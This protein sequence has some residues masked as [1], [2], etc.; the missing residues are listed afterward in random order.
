MKPLVAALFAV[1]LAFGGSAA[2]LEPPVGSFPRSI[3]SLSNALKAMKSQ[4]VDLDSKDRYLLDDGTVAEVD[5]PNSIHDAAI[6]F[7]HVECKEA[8]PLMIEALAP[9]E[10]EAASHQ[11][12]LCTS[13]HLVSALKAQTGE[14]FG[15]RVSDWRKWWLTK[16]KDLPDSFYARNIAKN[17]RAN[18]TPEPTPMS[19]T[20]PAAQEPR[21]P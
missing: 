2:D 5:G 11:P 10:T 9:Y 21:Q 6:F 8:V 12:M 19:V 20:P 4:A 18:Q 1:G 14:D 15:Y 13:G 7:L 16:G 3:E 17:H